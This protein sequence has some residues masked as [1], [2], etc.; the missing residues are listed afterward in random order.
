MSG[1]Y[2]HVNFCPGGPGGSPQPLRQCFP[3]GALRWSLV[4]SMS[5]RKGEYCTEGTVCSSAHDSISVRPCVWRLRNCVCNC[6]SHWK[7]KQN[8]K[9]TTSQL[10]GQFLTWSWNLLGVEEERGSAGQNLVKSALCLGVEE[11]RQSSGPIRLFSQLAAAQIDYQ[12][13]P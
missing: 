12:F 7:T 3:Q 1:I 11:Y 13:R 4:E 5:E 8:K 9:I 10:S 6:S 2:Q